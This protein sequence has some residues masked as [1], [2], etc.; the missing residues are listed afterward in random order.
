MA[1]Q[2]MDNKALAEL[3]VKASVELIEGARST[4]DDALA[5]QILWRAIGLDGTNQSAWLWR[6]K[7]MKSDEDKIICFEH[8]IAINPNSEAGRRAQRALDRMRQTRTPIP[9]TV[10]LLRKR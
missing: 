2:R 5:A 8:V 1:I 7:I 9:P 10:D 6:A 3:L 4:T